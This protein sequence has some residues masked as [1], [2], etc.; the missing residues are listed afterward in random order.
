VTENGFAGSITA[1]LFLSRFVER[2]KAWAHLDIYAWN[3][4]A[5]PGRPQGGEAMGL[6]C[7]FA[8]LEA[9]YKNSG[10]RRR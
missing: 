7:V 8:C 4:K 9:R 10:K 3:N 5:R 2:A 6:R 1:A